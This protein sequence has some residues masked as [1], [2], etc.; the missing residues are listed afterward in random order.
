MI[1]DDRSRV[2]SVSGDVGGTGLVLRQLADAVYLVGEMKHVNQRQ[3][4][5]ATGVRSQLTGVGGTWVLHIQNSSPTWI[6]N[7]V[8]KVLDYL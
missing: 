6:Y 5:E 1:D 7:C 2:R 3:V 4:R 8:P